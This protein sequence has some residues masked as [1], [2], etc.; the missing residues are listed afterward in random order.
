[1]KPFHNSSLK[2]I[3]TIETTINWPNPTCRP[4][5]GVF[6][7][8]DWGSRLKEVF[9]SV[10]PRGSDHII[11]MMYV[12]SSYY[13]SFSISYTRTF[14]PGAV[15]AAMRTRWSLP[16]WNTQRP[17]SVVEGQSSQRRSLPPA[18]PVKPRELPRCVS[19]PST[20]GDGQNVKSPSMMMFQLPWS[21]PGMPEHHPQ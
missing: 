3:L 19:S 6:P 1:M 7:N 16:S 20:A 5:L 21:V 15:P 8:E 4:A 17:I 11:T 10:A 9:M 13:F 18:C 2:I 14:P 12:S